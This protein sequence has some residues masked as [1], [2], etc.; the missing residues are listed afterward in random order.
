MLIDLTSLTPSAP[1]LHFGC[2]VQPMLH[3]EKCEIAAAPDI[4][5]GIVL[6]GNNGITQVGE[7]GEQ[8]TSL[9][10]GFGGG[11]GEQILP[12]AAQGK[13][14]LKSDLLRQVVPALS[15]LCQHLQQSVITE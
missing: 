11:L 1:N 3:P 13:L 8:H 7:M 6:A 15:Q 14:Y 9:G 2:C 4:Q 10:A 12:F 5:V